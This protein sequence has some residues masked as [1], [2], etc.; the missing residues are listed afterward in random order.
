MLKDKTFVED[1][2]Y[3]SGYLPTLMTVEKQLANT[4]HYKSV[5]SWMYTIDY[6]H[7]MDEACFSWIEMHKRVVEK[8]L[9]LDEQPMMQ[10]LSSR[11]RY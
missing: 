7:I 1:R 5:C 11:T 2:T 3:S 9:Y 6:A 4:M 10:H 8:A